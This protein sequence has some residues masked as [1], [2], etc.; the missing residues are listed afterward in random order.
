MTLKINLVGNLSVSLYF[1]LD[2]DEKVKN[3]FSLRFWV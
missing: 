2:K 3:I 1:I